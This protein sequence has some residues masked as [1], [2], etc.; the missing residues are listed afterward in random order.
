MRINL[1]KLMRYRRLFELWRTYVSLKVLARLIYRLPFVLLFP[2]RFLKRYARADDVFTKD[3]TW[4]IE[5]LR[6]GRSLQGTKTEV[7]RALILRDVDNSRWIIK[8]TMRR[9]RQC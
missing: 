9:L 1:N 8:S 3:G 7:I 4:Y 6:D 5:W 2:G